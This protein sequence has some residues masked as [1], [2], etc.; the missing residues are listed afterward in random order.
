[1][2]IIGEVSWDRGWTG[3]DEGVWDEEGEERGRKEDYFWGKVR[4][5]R[6][7]G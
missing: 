2:E 5:R 4:D 7:S 3:E 1:M 6:D